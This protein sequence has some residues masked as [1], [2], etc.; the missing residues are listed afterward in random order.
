M[1][2]QPTEETLIIEGAREHNL[3]NVST[4][5]PRNSLTIITGLSGSGKSS[6]AFDTIY[7]EGQR[8]AGVVSFNLFTPDYTLLHPYDVGMLL[9]QQ[10]IAVRSGHHCAEPLANIIGTVGTVRASFALYNEEQDIE[11]LVTALRRT[12]NILRLG[13]G[14]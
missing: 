8:K 5:I 2:K 7:A 12:A 1:T 4:F 3:K 14:G 10:G 6:L 9:D 13:S 11:K